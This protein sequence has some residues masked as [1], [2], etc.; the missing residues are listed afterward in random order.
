MPVQIRREAGYAQPERKMFSQLNHEYL[1]EQIQ[2]QGSESHNSGSSLRLRTSFSHP[3]KEIVIAVRPNA[4]VENGA[5]RWTDF[6]YGSG[7]NA[8]FDPTRPAAGV[9]YNGSDP[10]RD[11][12]IQL[13]ATDRTSLMP[14]AYWGIVQPY[15]HHTNIPTTGIYLYSFALKPEEHQ[16]SGTLNASRIEGLNVVMTL[17][18]G[19]AG[20][21]I[22]PF[23]VNYNVLRI[24]SGMGGLAYAS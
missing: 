13:N 15:Y 23:A 20:V 19:T 16:P 9:G 12:K 3:C 22:F 10:L 17:N 2:H 5:N 14:A 24:T 7:E 11:A 4:N 18:T 1:I 21:T 6:T 8:L